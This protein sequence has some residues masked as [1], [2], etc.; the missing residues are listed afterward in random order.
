MASDF[1]RDKVA[2]VFAEMDTDNDG[3]LTEGDFRGR[4]LGAVS[5]P[6]ICGLAGP[7]SGA[8]PAEAFG[9][10]RPERIVGEPGTAVQ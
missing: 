8:G 5:P 7:V 3:Y 6:V 1:Q 4:P 9:C 2:R 10:L